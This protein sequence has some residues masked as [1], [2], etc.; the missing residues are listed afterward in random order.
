MEVNQFGTRMGEAFGTIAWLWIFYRF[1]QDGMVLLG[2]EH[3]WE[4]GHHSGDHHGHGG[5]HG[6]KELTPAERAASWEVFADKAVNPGD[7]DDDDDDDEEE[8]EDED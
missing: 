5:G 8:E 6:H 1:S 3:P 4:H 2:Y 7:D